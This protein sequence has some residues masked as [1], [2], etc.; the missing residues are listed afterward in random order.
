V[1][2]RNAST[3]ATTLMLTFFTAIFIGIRTDIPSIS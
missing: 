3:V 1:H 2:K